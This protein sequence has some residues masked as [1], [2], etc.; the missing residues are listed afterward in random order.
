[1]TTVTDHEH[2][3]RSGSRR[4][5]LLLSTLTT[6][7]LAA[8]LLFAT[9]APAAAHDEIV[10]SSPEAG[11]TVS[12]VPEEISL[13]FSGETLR[14]VLR[15]IGASVARSGFKKFVLLGSHGGNVG[16]LDD[17]FRDL[18]IETD[19][20]VFKIFLGGIG[21][22]LGSLDV[23]IPQGLLVCHV[24]RQQSGDVKHGVELVFRENSI[25]RRPIAQVG[26]D[27]YQVGVG[28]VIVLEVEINARP[29]RI[30]QVP[31]K[32]TAKE[33]GAAGDNDPLHGIPLANDPA[34]RRGLTRA[35]AID[36]NC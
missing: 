25:H 14:M 9:A 33:P 21:Q 22:V 35:W 24:V 27:A 20:R 30:Q 12:V 1:M 28:I 19:M 17:F 13:T 18:R 11:S 2:P 10:S 4:R 36:T 23:G 26:F 7:L 3:H 16:T 34:S 31:L 5:I 29:A 32:N 8:G 15:D 6:L